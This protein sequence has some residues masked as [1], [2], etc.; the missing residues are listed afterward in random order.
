MKAQEKKAT[1]LRIIF[2][3]VTSTQL[4]GAADGDFDNLIAGEDANS[5]GFVEV[6]LGG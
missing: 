1:I 5:Y 3:L 2:P 4:V 6:K